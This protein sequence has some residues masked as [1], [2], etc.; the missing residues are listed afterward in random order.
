MKLD[1]NGKFISYVPS[2]L[3]KYELSKLFLNE[4]FE[5]ICG[6]IQKMTEKLIIEW[7]NYWIKKTSIGQII[8]SG[9]VFMNIKA[10]K[11]LLDLDTIKSLFVVPSSGDESCVFG[12][13]WKMNKNE[14]I[15]TKKIT[16]LYYGKN[17]END[18]RNF[19]KKN[20]IEKQFNVKSV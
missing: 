18:A 16:N 10:C 12:A 20:N 11:E 6:A 15:K 8:V 5:N 4:K 17:Y 13:L 3:Y 9:G 2:N 14:R 7:V 1:N 19:I